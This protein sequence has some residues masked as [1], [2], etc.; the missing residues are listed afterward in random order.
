MKKLIFFLLTIPLAFPLL[1][2]NTK[3]F[4]QDSLVI[5]SFFST[6]LTQGKAYGN[7]EKLCKEAVPRLSGSPGAARAVELMSSIMRQSGFDSVWLQPV[8]VPHWVRG[9][10]ELG[11]YISSKGNRENLR[12]C[13][14]GGS[15]AT[16]PGGLKAQII[17]VDSISQLEMLGQKNIQGKIVFF[18][19]P[20]PEEKINTFEAYG[21]SVDQRWAGPSAAAKYG[22]LATICR[23][24]EVGIS[25]YP[26]TG[27]MRYD[28][29]YPKIPCVAIS[30]LGANRLH[31]LLQQEPQGAFYMELN[32]KTLPDELSYNVI[33]E[34]RGSVH[35]EEILLAGGHLDAWDNGEG[36]HDDGAGCVQSMDALWL[37]VKTGIRPKRTIRA[38]L[39]MNEE[40]GLRG[41]LEYARL[42]KQNKEKHIL[43][44]ETDQ[45]GFTPRGF[46]LTAD[47]SK[48]AHI[49]TFLKLFYPYHVTEFD[50]KG[51]GADIGPLKEQGVP[52]MNYFPDPQ[53]Y[54]D[55]HHTEI[56][57]FKNVNRRELHLGSATIASML[58]LISEYGW[59]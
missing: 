44:I 7:L 59:P 12:I 36:A 49:R 47:N 22:A 28:S 16:A 58:Y 57:V 26:H 25:D 40:N 51:G 11:M 5:A 20:M 4:Q 3:T 37:F 17:E 24:M 29:L 10:K 48:L 34:I 18:N 55:V 21:A 2:Q 23:S 14:L 46:R 6:S 50:D 41:G 35:P 1:G 31:N 45:G 42:A 19:R 33:G 15:V 9:N 30:T 8:M 32:C 27:S 38:V 39:F 13:A 56:D 53:R 43:A 52:V 54:F